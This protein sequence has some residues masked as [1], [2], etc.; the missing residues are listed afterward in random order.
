MN[1]RMHADAEHPLSAFTWLA[2]AN[3]ENPLTRG[4]FKPQE[5]D[6]QT[7]RNYALW[8]HGVA[9]TPVRNRRVMIVMSTLEM[10]SVTS[11]A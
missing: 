11:L 1:L 8:K 10:C 4:L 7:R 5:P 3:T 6:P 2:T 9:A